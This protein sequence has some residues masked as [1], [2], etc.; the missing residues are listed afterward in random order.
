[1]ILF[2]DTSDFHALTFIL[3]SD[4]DN[5]HMIKRFQTEVA[6]NE[7][8]KTNEL[9]QKFLKREKVNVKD[10][11][12]IIVC[13]GPGSFTGIRV[14]VSLAQALGYGLS[15]PVMAIPKSK[16]PKDVRKLATLQGAKTLVMNYGQKPNITKAKKIGSKNRLFN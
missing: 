8:Y 5:G 2:I 13:T 6:F 16:V 1:M 11:A 15:I 10:L 9:L 3:V 12:K 4:R 7:N 14:G